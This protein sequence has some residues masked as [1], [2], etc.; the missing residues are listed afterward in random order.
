MQ[1]KFKFR[2]D[3]GLDILVSP[4]A[5]QTF[6]RSLHARK[7]KQINPMAQQKNQ[8]NGTKPSVLGLY[9]ENGRKF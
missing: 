6:I 4:S 8:D 2:E 5:Q 1:Y 7:I 3:M 9:S